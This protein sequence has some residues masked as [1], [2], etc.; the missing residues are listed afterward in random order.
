MNTPLI[1]GV[2]AYNQ[3]PTSANTHNQS[4]QL[5]N[6]N[7]IPVPPVSRRGVDM[8]AR[9]GVVGNFLGNRKTRRTLGKK[10][11]LGQ[12]KAAAS[13]AELQT[14]NQAMKAEQARQAQELQKVRAI[15][16]ERFAPASN[17]TETLPPIAANPNVQQSARPEAA[18]AVTVAAEQQPIDPNQPIELQAKQHFERTAWWNVVVDD[19]GREVKGA[20]SYGEE[21]KKQRRETISDQVGMGLGTAAGTTPVA[22]DSSTPYGQSVQQPSLP[23]GMTTPVLPQG[24][25]THIDPQHQLPAKTKKS[26]VVPGPVFWVMLVVILAAFFAAASF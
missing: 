4:P 19:K 14:Q 22:Q 20:M 21:F 23:S 8:L 2:N 6:Y 3:S 26:D 18:A 7:T 10:I 12:Q 13:F 25:P 17:K 16:A 5:P 15:P 9:I 24:L 11:E 1:N